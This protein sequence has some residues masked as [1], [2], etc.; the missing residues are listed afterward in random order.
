MKWQYWMDL[1]LGRHCSARGL[2]A[3]TIAA[4]LEV[5]RMFRTF[6]I[7]KDENSGPDSVK[8]KDVLE[9]VEYLR[10]VRHNQN[11]A[12]NR[13]VVV[14]TNFYRAAVAFGQMQP[15]DNPMT[16]FPKL[17]AVKR[18]FKDALS[19]DEVKKLIE[20]PRVDTILGIR[21]R[22]MISLLYGTG[23]RVT[24]CCQLRERNVDLEHGT[25]RVLG[26]GGDERVVPLN[27]KVIEELRQYRTARGRAAKDAF[28]FKSRKSEGMTRGA[29]YER[30]TTHARL[31]RIPKHVSPHSLRHTFA[32]H[33]VR[34][35][36]KIPVLRDLL[37]HRQI[38]STQIYI[39][40]T[41]HDLRGAVDRHP[42]GK[43]VESLKEL[44]PNV[45][46]PFQYPPGM[47]FAFQS[48]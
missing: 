43:L 39:H 16:F 46:L 45:K 17:K 6:M 30:V 33:L 35:G 14:I 41:A 4:Y 1:Y 29:V 3:K 12:V 48:R 8:M 27:S 9:Y 44:L 5:L 11:G 42:I 28:F 32:T 24:E 26:K 38:S 47:R 10:D 7:T 18:K 19:E 31:S 2:Q 23:I 36:T 37:G 22:A 20:Q 34:I 21:D 25:I 40:M 15:N 13:Q